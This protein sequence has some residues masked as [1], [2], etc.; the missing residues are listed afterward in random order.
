MEERG[1]WRGEVTARDVM[2]A[3]AGVEDTF[4]RM[5]ED[6]QGIQDGPPHPHQERNDQAAVAVYWRARQRFEYVYGRYVG[7]NLES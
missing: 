2:N 1:I 4:Q 5:V 7:E 6:V 3:A